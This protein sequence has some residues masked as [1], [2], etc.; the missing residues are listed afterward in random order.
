MPA[1]RPAR[2]RAAGVVVVVAVVVVVVIRVVEVLV[3]RDTRSIVY[4]TTHLK[5][6]EAAEDDLPRDLVRVRVNVKV[7]VKVRVRAK[8]RPSKV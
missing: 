6:G 3:A 4:S 5:G 8:V 1:G 7:R 2:G